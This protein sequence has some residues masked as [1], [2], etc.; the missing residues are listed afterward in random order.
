MLDNIKISYESDQEV[1]EAVKENE[2]FIKNETLALEIVNE[3]TDSEEI[4]LNSHPSKI[5]VEKVN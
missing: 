4:D 5:K 1:V 2:D 3:N